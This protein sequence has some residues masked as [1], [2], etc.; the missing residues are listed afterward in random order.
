MISIYLPVFRRV[1][2]HFNAGKDPRVTVNAPLKR[3]DFRRNLM[4]TVPE[5]ERGEAGEEEE[6]RKAR[7]PKIRKREADGRTGVL[8][9][10]TH[11]QRHFFDPVS[12]TSL[13]KCE[14]DEC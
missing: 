11:F 7:N 10:V 6:E 4:Q 3:H 9:A 13:V 12:N 2:G 5:E 1:I 8:S 14:L